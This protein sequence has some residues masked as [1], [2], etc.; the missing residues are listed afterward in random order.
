MNVLA[1]FSSLSLAQGASSTTQYALLIAA[2][3]IAVLGPSSQ[4]VVEDLKP[5]TSA[6]LALS[7]LA[8]LSLIGV[9]TA[10]KN[11]PFIYF[12]F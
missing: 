3:L 9:L 10:D 1:G 6:A 8:V 2:L 5:R 11:A 12:Q 7:T 4:R